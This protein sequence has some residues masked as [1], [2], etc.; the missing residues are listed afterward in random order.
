[1]ERKD[2]TYIDFCMTIG[3]EPM[4]CEPLSTCDCHTSRPRNIQ[5]WTKDA[6]HRVVLTQPHW[7]HVMPIDLHID[8]SCIRVDIDRTLMC[9]A[10]CRENYFSV[11]VCFVGTGML[12]AP[13]EY[14]IGVP[15]QVAYGFPLDTDLCD[16][17]NGGQIT[18]LLEPATEQEIQAGIY[19]S[20]F[21]SC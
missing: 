14:T 21:R 6:A 17:N 7:V 4:D 9:A 11:P 19:N 10:G 1:M 3:Y 12:L 15:Q 2:C 8:S 5:M 18:L 16:D 13:G 20:S